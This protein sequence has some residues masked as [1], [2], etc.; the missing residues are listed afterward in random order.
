MITITWS[1]TAVSR[2]P[3]GGDV[4]STLPSA[5]EL[6]ILEAETCDVISTVT[7]HTIEDGASIT[8]HQVPQLD[9][10]RFDV[11]TSDSPMSVS[12]GLTGTGFRGLES[13]QTVLISPDIRKSEL[14]LDT[15]QRLCRE[16]IQVNI[17]GLRKE[18][19][20]WIITSVTADRRTETTGA[21]VASITA[22]EVVTTKLSEVEAPAPMVERVRPRS[23][24]GQQVPRNAGSGTVDT[25]AA[26]RD[27]GTQSVLEP[28]YNTE[29]GEPVL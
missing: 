12:Q 2:A 11:M 6:D 4:L 24:A 14:A 1:E 22:Q 18:I 20:D 9:R 25:T 10:V 28:F 3:A 21:L 17:I 16:G 7:E 13:G 5:L 23:S 26:G 15:L 27:T 19:A 8:D 29:T